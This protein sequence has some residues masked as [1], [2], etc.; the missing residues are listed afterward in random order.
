MAATSPWDPVPE[1]RAALERLR[2][3]V[4]GTV[5]EPTDDRYEQARAVW[6]GMIDRRP[7]AIVRAASVEDIAPVIAAARETD[8][9]WRCAAAATASPVSAPSTT[10]SCWTWVH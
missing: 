3:H 6:N 8:C 10:A 9:R 5:I 4:R 7:R 1:A 2:S